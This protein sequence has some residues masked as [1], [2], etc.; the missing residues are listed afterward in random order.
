[1]LPLPYELFIYFGAALLYFSVEEMWSINKL[2]NIIIII[3]MQTKFRKVVIFS[4]LKLHSNLNSVECLM[5]NNG[6]LRSV[7]C[8][9]ENCKLQIAIIILMTN[10]SF[11]SFWNGILRA[12]MNYE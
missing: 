12:Q 3:I 8:Q 11:R 10:S 5:T 7:I 9:G 2:F 1:M 6:I 4:R